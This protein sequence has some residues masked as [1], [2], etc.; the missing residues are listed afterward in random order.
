MS[1]RTQHNVETVIRAVGNKVV[2]RL[3]QKRPPRPNP[4]CPEV[5]RI[6]PTKPFAPGNITWTHKLYADLIETLGYDPD[7][8]HR[9][10][11]G[12]INAYQRGHL[13]NPDGTLKAF[14]DVFRERQ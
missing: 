5:C 8:V 12:V 2:E 14:R 3:E 9:W 7:D 10:V 11:S 1:Q 6:D 4:L 13:R